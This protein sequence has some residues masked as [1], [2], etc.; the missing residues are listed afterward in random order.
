MKKSL[1]SGRVFSTL[2]LPEVRDNFNNSYFSK[3]EKS[4]GSDNN[5]LK[6]KLVNNDLIDLSSTRNEEFNIRDKIN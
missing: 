4:F 3:S 6:P 1:S 2:E 5:K